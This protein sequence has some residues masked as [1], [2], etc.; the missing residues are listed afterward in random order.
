MCEWPGV[1]K[2]RGNARKWKWKRKE[3][4]KIPGLGSVLITG[5]SVLCR[6]ETKNKTASVRLVG[7]I[8][9]LGGGGGGGRGGEKKKKIER[10]WERGRGG[11]V[12]GGGGEKKKKK[13]GGGGGG[14]GRDGGGGGGGGGKVG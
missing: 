4:L 9:R 5:Y 7:W 6:A 8:D 13:G 1:G 12:G 10:G 14:G 2:E 11:R 3:Y